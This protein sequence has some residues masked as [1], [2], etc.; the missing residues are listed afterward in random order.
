M[1]TNWPSLRSDL[2]QDLGYAHV[3]A[4]AFYIGYTN[5]RGLEEALNG[6]T[7]SDDLMTALMRA[8]PVVPALYFIQP[9]R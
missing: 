6:G 2:L 5:V 9:N 1:T 8:F 7:P 4:L 3:E